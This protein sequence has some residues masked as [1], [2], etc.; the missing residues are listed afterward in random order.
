M[1]LVA[2]G[3]VDVY[4]KVKEAVVA[5]AAPRRVCALAGAQIPE[6]FMVLALRLLGC[7]LLQRTT[8]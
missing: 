3:I 2:P 5:I 8:S 7:R 6:E 1:V 4:P